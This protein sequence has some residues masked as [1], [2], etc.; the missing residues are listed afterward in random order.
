MP[1]P[2]Q[3]VALRGRRRVQPRRQRFPGQRPTLTKILGF[4]DTPARFSLVDAQPIS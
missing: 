4:G 2:D 3:A 1:I